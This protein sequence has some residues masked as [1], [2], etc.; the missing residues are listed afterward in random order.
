VTWHISLGTFPQ[1]E[2]YIFS[3]FN[4]IAFMSTLRKQ[5]TYPVRLEVTD[6][7]I[8]YGQLKKT[9]KKYTLHQIGHVYEETGNLST[10]LSYYQKAIE[11]LTQYHTPNLPIAE[12]SLT[13]IQQKLINQQPPT[14]E[15]P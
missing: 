12:R 10:A 9:G 5:Y 3:I 15:T 2:R 1:T 14:P 7:A 6:A 8:E 13:R 4:E 11:D